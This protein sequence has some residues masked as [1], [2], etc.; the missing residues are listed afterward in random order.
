MS[1]V[2]GYTTRTLTDVLTVCFPGKTA[3]LNSDNAGNTAAYVMEVFL[4]CE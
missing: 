4:L 2:Q 3:H 1:T